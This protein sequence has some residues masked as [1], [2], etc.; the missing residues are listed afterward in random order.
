M[1]K[2]TLVS[3]VISFPA[4]P[5]MAQ[6]ERALTY[7]IPRGPLT[8]PQPLEQSKVNQGQKRTL[9]TSIQMLV[10][11]FVLTF[12]LCQFQKYFLYAATCLVL[13]YHCCCYYLNRSNTPFSAMDPPHHTYVVFSIVPCKHHF[14]FVLS[15]YFTQ[16]NFKTL[17]KI[18]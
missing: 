16:I 11:D 8:L 10:L 2:Q 6:G 18:F 9:F 15:F 12:R 5:S 4:N 14:F 17:L 13:L 1:R 3:L 7:Y